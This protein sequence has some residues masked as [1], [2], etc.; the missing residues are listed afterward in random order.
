M[1]GPRVKTLA[2]F[3]LGLACNLSVACGEHLRVASLCPSPYTGQ[4]TIDPGPDGSTESRRY[5]TSCAPCDPAATVRFDRH[6]CP[7]YVTAES[8]GGDVCL[9]GELISP[10]AED[11]AGLDDGGAEDAR[12]AR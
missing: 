12:A 5:G 11:D 4:A 9:F 2:W 7:I 3:V 10:S 6:G 1:R 8:C